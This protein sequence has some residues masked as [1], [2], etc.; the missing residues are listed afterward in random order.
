MTSATEANVA[1]YFQ[2][3]KDWYKRALGNADASI[4]VFFLLVLFPLLRVVVLL[5]GENGFC[6]CPRCR[7]SIKFVLF[8]DDDCFVSFASSPRAPSAIR[9]P[10]FSLAFARARFFARSNLFGLFLLFFS[11]PRI[12]K[13]KLISH[14]EEKTL[15]TKASPHVSK[16]F[17]AAQ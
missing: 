17:L 6:F 8:E 3:E 13:K 7:S 11:P 10:L 5:V 2:S 12:L 4:I 9:I 16:R 1:M 15:N 14:R